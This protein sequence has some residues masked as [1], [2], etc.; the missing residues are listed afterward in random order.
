MVHNI[1]RRDMLKLG[2]VSLGGLAFN[3]WERLPLEDRVQLDVL[4]TVRVAIRQD[5]IWN[6]PSL[7]STIVGVRKRDELIRVY[8]EFVSPYGPDHNPRWYKVIGGYMHSA[9]LAPVET[10]LNPVKWDID[11]TGMVFE[12]TV[13]FAKTMRKM[14]NGDWEPLYRLYYKSTHWVTGID[15][16]PMECPGIVCSMMF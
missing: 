11:E 8:D 3:R 16:V 2:A 10:F 14:V 7:K 12:V 13:P 9:H 6:E 15:E 4:K 5:E 1:S